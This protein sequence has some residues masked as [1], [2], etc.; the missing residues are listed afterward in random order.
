MKPYYRQN[1]RVKKIMGERG[2]PGKEETWEEEE[3]EG[4]EEEEKDEDEDE[5]E[6]LTALR[7]PEKHL[8]LKLALATDYLGASA[9]SWLPH[10]SNFSL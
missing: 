6:Y 4:E 5:D 1:G 9:R 10:A 8:P 7:S 3:E 2:G